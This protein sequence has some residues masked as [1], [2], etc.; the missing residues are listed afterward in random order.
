MK[1]GVELIEKERNRQIDKEGWD[2]KH[3]DEHGI[4]A[5]A[6]AGACYALDYAGQDRRETG[7]SYCS[8]YEEFARRAWPWDEQDWKPT[9]NDPVKQLVKAGALIA[10]EID[11]LQRM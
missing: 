5:L 7:G 8:T 9:P 2:A 4:G 11:R 6:V 10:A 1:S 3:D